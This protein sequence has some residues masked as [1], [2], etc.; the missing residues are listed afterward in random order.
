M[1]DGTDKI[2]AAQLQKIA[3]TTPQAAATLQLL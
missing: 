1:P 2:A 3:K